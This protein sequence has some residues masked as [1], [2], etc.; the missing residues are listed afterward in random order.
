MDSLT[1]CSGSSCIATEVM[2]FQI[3]RPFVVVLAIAVCGTA[4]SRRNAAE[5]AR[6]GHTYFET[7]HYAEAVLEFRIALQQNPALGDV[8]LT[9]GDAYLQ[10]HDLRNALREY[11]RAADLLPNQVDA[12]LKAG[13]LLLLAAQFEDAKARADRAIALEPKNVAAQVLRGNALAGLKDFDAAM[14]EYQDAIA[15]DPAQP[16]AYD[17]L[18][19]LQLA[20][21]K[22]DQAEASFKSAVDAAPAS[23]P[24]RLALANFYW[25]TGRREDAEAALK[26]TV[27]L[28]RDNATANRALGLFYLGT[29]I[30]SPTRS[31]TSW[32]SRGSKSDAAAITLADYYVVANRHEDARTIL[33]ERA[34]SPKTFASANI[35]L[36]SL[37]ASAGIGPRHSA[38]STTCSR[39][40]RIM[41]WRCWSARACRSRMDDAM[42]PRRRPSH[43]RER[44]DV[45]GSG[46]G[47][48]AHRPPR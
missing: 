8:R 42:R 12:Q 2:P 33:R 18:A 1:S 13:Q 19:L 44:T 21:G 25:S 5:H 30:A 3:V 32:R 31:P 48:A 15:L 36:A 24:A 38:A 47:V 26:A 10:L 41:R 29:R 43:R 40:S 17:N 20:Q 11:M 46:R 39:K 4:C 14:S 16:T 37:D 7:Q 28:D 27:A 9:L 22:R 35:R 23:V 45:G 6:R 34:S